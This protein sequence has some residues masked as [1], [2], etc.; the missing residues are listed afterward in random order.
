MGMS[1]KLKSVLLVAGL[2]LSAQATVIFEDNFTGASGTLLNGRSPNLV[3]TEGNT[4]T[5]P[6][7]LLLNGSGWAVSTNGSGSA[8][9]AM[10][11]LT[12]NETVIMTAVLRPRNTANNW[13]GFGFTDVV[14]SLATEGIAWAFLRGGTHSNGGRV[15]VNSGDGTTG[16]LYSSTAAE[17][18]W[19]G[20]TDPSTMKITYTVGTGNMKVELGTQTVFEGLIAYN[21]AAG[22]PAPLEALNYFTFQWSSQNIDTSAA[23]G[24]FDSI[25]V[26]VIPEPATIGMLGLGAIVAALIRRFKI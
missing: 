24:Y 6:T 4:Y 15:T 12:A 21:G 23:P 8:S 19:A 18:G 9:I 20:A 1:T 10:P 16:A 7:S 25:K 13:M 11:T 22:T 2:C 3:N 26:E 14:G 5:A 17:V